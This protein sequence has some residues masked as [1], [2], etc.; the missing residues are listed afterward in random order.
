M[1]S[2][3][4]QGRVTMGRI[5]LPIVSFICL[6]CWVVVYLLLPIHTPEKADSYLLHQLFSISILPHWLNWS[7]SFLLYATI[8]YLLIELNNTFSIIRIRASIQTSLYFFLLTACPTIYPFELTHLATLPFLISL[9]LLFKSYH[10]SHPVGYIFHSFV[11]MGLGSLLFPQLTFFVPLWLLTA[12]YYQSLT[13]RSFCA[14]V[15]GWAIPYWFLFGYAFFYN[16][17]ELFYE[18]FAQLTLLQPIELIGRLQLWEY[19]TYGFLF[20]VF[21]ISTIHVAITGYLDKIQTRTYLQFLTYLVL[22][23]FLFIVLQPMYAASLLPLLLIGVSFLVARLFTLSTNK[24]SNL[25]FILSL[26]GV[27]LLFFFNLWTL[28]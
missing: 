7:F 12:V 3:T 20:V 21:L 24:V 1:R 16:Q 2:T 23:I 18:P 26:V 25:F 5:T 17:M 4:I 28:L 11:S 15:V 14:A 9:Y 10:Q 19:A 6:C 13:I 8:G 22:Y 27:I